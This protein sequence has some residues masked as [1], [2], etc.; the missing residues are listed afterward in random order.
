[1][2]GCVVGNVTSVSTGA[3]IAGCVCARVWADQ[4]ADHRSIGMSFQGK[5]SSARHAVGP[6]EPG[7]AG[8]NRPVML[9]LRRSVRSRQAPRLGSEPGRAGPSRAGRGG[10]GLI[11]HVYLGLA[12]LGL[13]CR[14]HG[15]WQVFSCCV[16]G[17]SIKM[18][19][20]KPEPV[21]VLAQHGL[22]CLSSPVRWQDPRFTRV[23]KNS[24]SVLLTCSSGRGS[25]GPIQVIQGISPWCWRPNLLQSRDH[26]LTSTNQSDLSELRQL[27][28]LKCFSLKH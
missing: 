28:C 17:R 15:C 14:G 9:R 11:R 25:I 27:E 12:R 6:P 22:I 19:G 1:M 23:F 2:S 20:L 26:Q 16:Q 10:A 21:P 4:S 3:T 7:R 13:V 8:E 18:H 24:S 5:K